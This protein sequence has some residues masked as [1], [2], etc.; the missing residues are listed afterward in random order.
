MALTPDEILNHEFTRK[1]S[2]AYVAR[3]VDSFLDEVNN[4]YRTLLADF[5]KLQQQNRQQQN[6][7]DELEGERDQ[8]NESIMFAQSA[9]SRLRSETESEVKSQLTH[10]QDEAKQIV[11]EAHQKAEAESARLAQEN[12]DL[13]DEQNRLR[14][15][16]D[17]FRQS[18]LSL[19]DQQKALLEQGQLSQAVDKLPASEL[20][21]KVLAETNDWLN[22]ASKAVVS[23]PTSEDSTEEKPLPT[24][25]KE[26]P[27][28]AKGPIE[29]S[30]GE[31]PAESETVEVEA[32]VADPT[33]V[34]FPENGQPK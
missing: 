12:V 33:V 17:S 4:D 10:A 26:V 22:P 5:E 16:V 27:S 8:V 15:R 29:P 21:E 32:E 18:F 23:A 2:R 19:I 6:R 25:I 3:E 1:G 14:Q 28:F 13:I 31:K 11:D 34:V 30:E 24:D 9:A 7:I 20:S